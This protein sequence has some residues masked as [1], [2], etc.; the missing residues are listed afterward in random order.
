MTFKSF[1][2]VL[3]KAVYYLGSTSLVGFGT[4]Y[5]QLSGTA[6]AAD[7][8]TAVR[9]GTTV[10]NFFVDPFTTSTASGTPSSGAYKGY[11]W[12]SD[13]VYGREVPAGTWRFN[14]TIASNRD[15]VG[16]I[17]IW[18]YSV[19]AAGVFYSNLFS[20]DASGTDVLNAQTAKFSFSY[21]SASNFDLSNYIL[22]V[23]YWLHVTAT[24]SGSST[25]KATFTTVSADSS[26]EIPE[27]T[28]HAVE[29][30][31]TG[32]SNT[33]AWTQLVWTID[34]QWTVGSVAVTL[35]LY[36]YTLG[37]Y[38]GS[39]D[40]YIAYTSNATANVD[41]TK[42]QT[43]TT[44]PS[45][46]RDG[47]GNWWIKVRGV[48]L[49]NLRFYVKVDL[50]E[51]R[52]SY[53]PPYIHDVAVLGVRVSPTQVVVGG[54]I[55]INVTVENHGDVAE[56][57]DVNATY[58]G[59]LIGVSHVD[60][61]KDANATLTFVWNTSGVAP[62]SY[63]VKAAASRV[64][65]ETDLADN[66]FTYPSPVVVVAPI[67]DII[68]LD[69]SVLPPWMY[70]G[71]SFDINVTV[72]NEGNVP[73]SFDINVFANLSLVGAIPVSDLDPS[74]LATTFSTSWVPAQVGAFEI[75]AEVPPLLGETDTADNNFT[76]GTVTVYPAEVHDVAVLGVTPLRG[77]VYENK[78]V[79]IDVVVRN[80][81]NVVE[82]FDVSVYAYNVTYSLNYTVGTQSVS[83]A[84]GE[85][86]VLTFSWDTTSVTVHTVYTIEAKALLP[87][88]SVPSDNAFTD[89]TVVV[90]LMGDVKDDGIVDVF[91]LIRVGIAFGSKPGEGNWNEYADLN[92]DDIIDVFD[93]ILVGINF[94]R[95]V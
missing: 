92:S 58:D 21:A 30:V 19:T 32:S 33:Y 87:G 27:Y 39:G 6:G 69:V 59:S 40:G 50:A 34:S 94:G 60:L 35:Q 85:T 2:S 37:G 77:W 20:V 41:E 18:V 78:T 82:T 28:E 83:L 64:P 38:P 72:Q 17:E 48:K 43:I 66:T 61:P 51:F 86:R 80:K 45:S 89:G 44:N 24:P 15:D 22:V 95:Q 91:D 76:D 75:S 13:G 93:L 56:S 4:D 25:A 62:G 67:H 47:A 81:G 52:V 68:V 65:D 46:F 36:N 49:T 12:R 88:D 11:G 90:R 1:G 53:I 5:R 9:Y 55:S 3:G 79:S 10:A 16:H 42:S 7:T 26:V 14:L 54:L 63:T 84:A 73:E 74:V 70:V 29:V 71:G 23:E 31:F 8:A 57:F